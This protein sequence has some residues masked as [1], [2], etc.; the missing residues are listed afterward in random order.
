[1]FRRDF[2]YLPRFSVFF[3]G[4]SLPRGAATYNCRFAKFQA[5]RR[6]GGDFVGCDLTHAF[7]AGDTFPVDLDE[8][9]DQKKQFRAMLFV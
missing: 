1:M 7:S 2:R 6:I 5:V 3:I 9:R 4:T 8:M